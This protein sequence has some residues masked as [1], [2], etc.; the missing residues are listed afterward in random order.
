MPLGKT[1]AV[2]TLGGILGMLLLISSPLFVSAQQLSV[3]ENN[4]YS[5]TTMIQAMASN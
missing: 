4:S 2:R 3:E 1:T 5:N